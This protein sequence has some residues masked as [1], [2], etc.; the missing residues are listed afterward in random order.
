VQ[1]GGRVP[2]KLVTQALPGPFHNYA[3]QINYTTTEQPPLRLEILRHQAWLDEAGAYH[4]SGELR[5]PVDTAVG[6][7]RIVATY[8]NP[9]NQVVRV[10][11]ALAGVDPLEPGQTAPFELILAGPP[12]DLS[13]YK[14]QTEAIRQ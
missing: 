9:A 6:G 12:G 5:N 8:Y 1:A 14:L 4:V 11:M 2:I 7:I 10:E 3:L 13:H